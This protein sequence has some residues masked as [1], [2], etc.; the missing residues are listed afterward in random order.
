MEPFLAERAFLCVLSS[1]FSGFSALR[2]FSQYISSV[3]KTE[4]LLK[5]HLRGRFLQN[6]FVRSLSWQILSF[7]SPEGYID[8]F[9]FICFLST[10]QLQNLFSSSLQPCCEALQENSQS[11][12]CTG[13]VP[14]NFYLSIDFET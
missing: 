12:F 3:E 6:M 13:I 14:Y 8:Y 9:F 7:V 2:R 10:I 4:R 1:A 5:F 11:K